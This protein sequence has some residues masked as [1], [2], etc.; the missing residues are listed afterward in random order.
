MFAVLLGLRGWVAGCPLRWSCENR[1]DRRRRTVRF[2]RAREFQFTRQIGWRVGGSTLS[3]R[4][5]R[6]LECRFRST[7]LSGRVRWRYSRSWLFV[8]HSRSRLMVRTGSGDRA[9]CGP[10]GSGS[11]PGVLCRSSSSDFG[12]GLAEKSPLPARGGLHVP[13]LPSTL[14]DRRRLVLVRS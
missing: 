2:S 13:L 14:S 4:T 11:S 6:L 8:V 1:T 3:Y 10:C 5:N 7:A 12:S 9:H